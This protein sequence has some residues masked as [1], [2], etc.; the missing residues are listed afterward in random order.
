MR[1][2]LEWKGY[3]YTVE[4]CETCIA[5]IG[6]KCQ[7]RNV[8][9]KPWKLKGRFP[10]AAYNSCPVY[11]EGKPR[12]KPVPKP[13]PETCEQPAIAAPKQKSKICCAWCSRPIEEM[14]EAILVLNWPKLGDTRFHHRHC[15][16]EHSRTIDHE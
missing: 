16:L 14:S 6:Q 9:L 3:L 15:H 4:S 8:I 12:K 1:H 11:E 13:P 10:K 7:A 5:R 2:I